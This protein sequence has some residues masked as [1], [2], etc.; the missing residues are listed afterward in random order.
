MRNTSVIRG[1]IATL[2]AS[3]LASSAL[4]DIKSFN[5]A[6]KAGDYK[7]A[8]EEAKPVWAEWDKTK[9]DTAIMAREFGFASY[10]A[11][12]FA[13]ARDYGQFLKDKGAT[14][15][16]PDDQP[17]TSRVLLA[18]ANHRLAAN[19]GT[20][21]ALFDAVKAREAASGLDSISL[22]AAE[23]LYRADWTGTNWTRASESGALAYRLISRGGEPLA[24]R[25]L[26]ARASGA[27][28]GFL[29][30]RDRDD[31]D[32]IVDT[33]DAIVKAIDETLDPRR[34]AAMVPLLFQ[35]QAWAHSVEAYF[36]ASD[37]IGSNIPKNV[38]R[39]DLKSVAGP[40]FPDAGVGPDACVGQFDAKA[41]DYPSSAMF[42]G[43]V[44]T[45][46]T[47]FDFDAQGRVVAHE[48]LAS[49]PA[50]HF[51][52]AVVKAVPQIR[53]VRKKEDPPGCSLESKSRVLTVSFKIL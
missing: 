43:M 21:N 39:R 3:L 14:L 5:A 30:G 19:D 28:A 38:K 25:A 27:T 13:A 18:A 34:R 35:M 7:K 22:L 49:V 33:H 53:L 16:T 45:V 32:N 37:Q 23:L 15:P 31:Y 40:L 51:A 20:R 29:G 36:G 9:P 52:D 17:A 50:R 10:V 47:K 1:L 8:S 11:G 48:V 24:P 42:K 6:V 4:A 41:L 2:C 26:E 44:G 46:I 12:D